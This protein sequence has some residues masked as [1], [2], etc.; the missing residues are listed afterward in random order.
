MSRIRDL[1]KGALLLLTGQAGSQLLSLLRNFIVARL[2]VPSSFGVAVTFTTTISLLN[3]ISDIGMDK[4][5]VQDRDG[6]DP[7]VQASLHTLIVARG[8]VT[9]L[10]LFVCAQPIA[11]LFGVPDQVGAYRWLA[12]VPLIAGFAHLDPIRAY[13][14]LNFAP[15]SIATLATQFLSVGVALVLVITMR[16]FRPIL[17]GL[18]AQ[19]AGYVVISHLL[20]RRRYELAY[21]KEY[22][23]RLATF[24][25]PLTINGLVL[26]AAGQGDRVA[27]GSTLGVHALAIYGAPMLISAAI[28]M[29][30]IKVLGSLMLSILAAAR[31]D[32]ASFD[33]F[34]HHTGAV[35]GLSALCVSVPF[36]FVGPEIIGLLYGKAYVGP[37]D[38][39]VFIGVS[40]GLYVMGYW[41]TI[42]A[43]ALGDS[44]NVMIVSIARFAGFCCVVPILALGYGDIVWVAAGMAF[45]QAMGVTVGAL[46]L[47]GVIKRPG[48]V[49]FTGFLAAIAVLVAT[50]LAAY[51]LGAMPVVARLALCFV[52]LAAGL[53]ALPLASR[54]YRDLAAELMNALPSAR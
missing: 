29:I 15:E 34:Y 38:L 44:K 54:D 6:D 16:D 46:R 22:A 50:G 41:A 45:G 11:D 36:M 9:A 39:F 35:I 47:G 19:S 37:P 14:Q 18:V 32:H 25:W 10:L 3:L 48:A 28:S 2:I 40:L 20:A 51:L 24:A 31:D 5:I 17:W 43:L 23:A 1:S 4:F 52:S 53:A 7:R 12:L 13:R 8:I 21:S 27:I 49:R 33:R 30:L 42:A 26:F